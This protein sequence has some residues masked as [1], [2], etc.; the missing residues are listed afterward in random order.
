[1]ESFLHNVEFLIAK[2]KQVPQDVEL[3]NKEVYKQI[4]D[5]E[6]KHKSLRELYIDLMF[7][8]SILNNTGPNAMVK[9]IVNK[10]AIENTIKQREML[11]EIIV[12]KYQTK[13]NIDELCGD[14][15][16]FVKDDQKLSEIPRDENCL[17]NVMTFLMSNIP[18]P[19]TFH[20]SLNCFRFLSEAASILAL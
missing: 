16:R 3:H 17:E 13:S 6:M 11:K 19:T 20:E 10:I 9:L 1:M 18:Q 14:L 4:N 8:E 15:M 2:Y 7:H 5:N 12:P